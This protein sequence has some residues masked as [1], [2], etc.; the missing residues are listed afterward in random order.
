MPQPVLPKVTIPL[1]EEWPCAITVF[2]KN[3]KNDPRI[4]QAI[5]Q[6]LRDVGEDPSGCYGMVL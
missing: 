2:I 5:K 1:T 4:T 6:A 3:R